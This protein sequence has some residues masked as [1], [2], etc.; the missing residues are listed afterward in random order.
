MNNSLGLLFYVKRSKM[1]EEGTAPVY[2][3]ITI[4]G[5]RIEVSSKRYVNPDKCNANGQKLGG[6]NTGNSSTKS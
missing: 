5:K 4:D 6:S 2:L 3:R 1:T